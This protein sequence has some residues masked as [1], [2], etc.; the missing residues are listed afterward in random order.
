MTRV[1][2]ELRK[3]NN[4]GKDIDIQVAI[5][6]SLAVCRI[7]VCLKR[8]QCSESSYVYAYK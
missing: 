6:K 3:L 4:H 7:H 5:V 1:T 8:S 2:V